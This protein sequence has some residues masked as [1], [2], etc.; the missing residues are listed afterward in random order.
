[1]RALILSLIISAG[2]YATGNTCTLNATGACSSGTCAFSATANSATSTPWTGTGCTAMS[3]LPSGD[4]I[5][6]GVTKL[7]LDTTLTIGTSGT[8]VHGYAYGVN[9]TTP[10]TGCSSTCTA[11][12]SGGTASTYGPAATAICSVAGGTATIALGLRG[13]YVPGSATPTVGVSGAG[14]GSGTYSL[15]FQPGNGT[16]ALYIPSGSEVDISGALMARGSIVWANDYGVTSRLVLKRGASL[17]MDPSVAGASTMYA[18]GSTLTGFGDGRLI[19]STDC[20]AS[21]PCTITTAA[22]GINSTM[23]SLGWGGGSSPSGVSL[24]HTNVSNFGDSHTPEISFTSNYYSVQDSSF[25]N[26]GPISMPVGIA[27]TDTRIHDRNV[28]A[29]SVTG[30]DCSSL[31][32]FQGTT[33][34]SSG[35]RSISGNV[36]DNVLMTNCGGS[37]VVPDFTV[38]NNYFGQATQ[39]S[40]S[41]GATFNGN[42][43]RGISL[44]GGNAVFAL[45]SA[46]SNSYFY[47]DLSTYNPHWITSSAVSTSA[48]EMSHFSPGDSGEVVAQS[49]MGLT[50]TILMPD[51]S[52]YATSEWASLVGGVYSGVGISRNVYWG[53]YWAPV[54]FG[55][56]QFNEGGQTNVGAVSMQDN[57]LYSDTGG[58]AGFYKSE[59]VTSCS[60]NTNYCAACSYNAGYNYTVPNATVS[61]CNNQSNGYGGNWASGW[62]TTNS[63]LDLDISNPDD[64]LGPGGSGRVNPW[65]ADST[66]QLATFASRYLGHAATAG[67]WASG[68]TYNYGDIVTYTVG[69]IYWGNPV[70]Y[71]CIVSPTCAAGS[72]AEPSVGASWRTNWELA[73]LYYLRQGVAAQTS[74]T[75]GA[76]GCSGCTLTQ[77]LLNW[78]FAGFTPQN[79]KLRGGAHDGSYVGAMPMLRIP[80]FGVTP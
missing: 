41:T 31:L 42:F 30:V 70:L 77:A 17:T 10:A 50:G 56:L 11:T 13:F 79:P 6:V 68:T 51:D 40:A 21:Q 49:G 20:T 72:T 45:P 74:I 59:V 4:N 28:H 71:R 58:S 76:I 78:V 33:A 29:G 80:A 19:D 67:T 38:A 64:N 14:C 32:A 66:R 62:H 1:M 39:F 35:T 3:Y 5:V 43:T 37:P 22:G 55:P 12:V 48:F 34:L 26:S 27:A 15:Q 23:G 36:F 73:S 53:R 54:V 18:L 46:A 65:F 44:Y 8:P 69:G 63:D 9:N 24:S 60:T 7:T 57:I 47:V 2:L 61:G 52:G 16:A 75:D 25:T